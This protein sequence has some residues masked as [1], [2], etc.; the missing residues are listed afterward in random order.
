LHAACDWY[1]LNDQ[2]VQAQSGGT[3]NMLCL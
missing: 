2:V 1:L 3:M